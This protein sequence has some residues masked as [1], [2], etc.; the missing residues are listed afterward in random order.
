M[1]FFNLFF[2]GD[3]WFWRLMLL[4]LFIGVIGDS[5]KGCI[6]AWTSFRIKSHMKILDDMEK[7]EQNE[8]ATVDDVRQ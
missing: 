5:I 2:T 3:G 8:S 7:E 4:M 6:E 1:E